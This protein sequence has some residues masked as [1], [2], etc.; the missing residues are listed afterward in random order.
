MI[1]ALRWG[2]VGAGSIAEKFIDALNTNLTTVEH[3]VV[4]ICSHDEERA[5]SFATKF[6]IQRFYAD[7]K[8]LAQDDMVEIAY[9]AVLNPQHYEVCLLMLRYGKHILC[10]TPFCMNEW[11]TDKVLQY[12]RHHELFAIA[13]IWSRF[14]PSYQH[15]K[16]MMERREIFDIREIYVKHGLKSDTNRRVTHKALGGGVV[17]DLGAYAIQFVLLCYNE[18]PKSIKATGKINSDNVDMYFEADLMFS[19]NRMAR[20]VCSGLETYDNQAV[21]ISKKGT[22]CLPSYCCPLSL[23][24]PDCNIRTWWIPE[25]E[26]YSNAT[27]SCNY[28]GLRYE[29]DEAA[30]CIR[31]K[32]IYS[33]V[34]SHDEMILIARIQDEIRRQIGVRYDCDKR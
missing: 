31:A 25:T 28:L 2:I 5:K 13:G 4:A 33:G 1:M 18:Y 12:A 21:I 23:I 16:A 24:E 14:F 10:E 22:V 15:L 8:S 17:L 7:Y 34:L 27:N 20:I 32:S 19:G 9:I 29:A 11:Q 3:K 6:K 26:K 30:K